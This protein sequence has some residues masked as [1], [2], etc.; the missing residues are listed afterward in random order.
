[1]QFWCGGALLGWRGSSAAAC[2]GAAL[3]LDRCHERPDADNIHD[4][5]E[6]VGKHV[7]GH[8]AGDAW[9]RLHQK[10]RR[11]HARL[12]NAE[13]L[14]DRL[15]PLAHGLRILVRPPLN[16]LEHM[17]VLPP[18]DPGLDTY[19]ARAFERAG[20]ARDGPVA[21]E[22]GE[23]LFEPANLLAPRAGSKDLSGWASG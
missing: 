22:L 3:R 20:P 11:A 4:A 10:V 18:R 12:D 21:S 13:G 23:L 15:A 2:K 19:R 1:M 16:G 17:L 14:L 8:L 6:I 5:R 9:Q 7:Q